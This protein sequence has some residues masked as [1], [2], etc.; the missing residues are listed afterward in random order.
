MSK[1]QLAIIL[2]KLKEFETPDV[3][4]EQ[5][6]TDSEIAAQ[7]IWDAYMKH[8]IEGKKI[9]DLGAGTGI[10]GLG[11]ALLAAD[12][13]FFVEKDP[14]AIWILK[15]NMAFVREITKKAKKLNLKLIKGDISKF[16]NKVDVVVQNPPFGTRDK[17]IDIKFLEKAMSLA[18]VVYTF[19]KYTTKEYLKKQIKKHGFKIAREY[20]LEHPIK[21]TMPHHKVRIK[22]I[23][24]V[25]FRLVKEKK[26]KA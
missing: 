26:S 19:H 12:T 2:S 3:Q 15:E 1:S 22:R 16:N 13:I 18:D 14:K 25:C 4:L 9:A 21:Q 10:L 7:I 5:Y 24:L 11:C 17:G 6:V 20:T 8:D 23:K